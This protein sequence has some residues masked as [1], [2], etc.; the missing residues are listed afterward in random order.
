MALSHG[1]LWPDGGRVTRRNRASGPTVVVSV[2]ARRFDPPAVV[3][4]GLTNA[5]VFPGWLWVSAGSPAYQ[6]KGKIMNLTDRHFPRATPKVMLQAQ[7]ASGLH[8]EKEIDCPDC[9]DDGRETT[10]NIA[11]SS[12][13]TSPSSGKMVTWHSPRPSERRPPT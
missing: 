2:A 6:P 1:H 3:C 12:E 10:H 5:F 4:A 8:A 13:L 11:P 9:V 7:H